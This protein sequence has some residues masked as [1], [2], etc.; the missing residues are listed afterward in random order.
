MKSQSP[1]RIQCICQLVPMALGVAIGSVAVGAELVITDSWDLVVEDGMYVCPESVETLRIADRIE[2]DLDSLEISC[3]Q[4]VLL[5]DAGSR[6]ANTGRVGLI[7]NELIAESGLGNP[8]IVSSVKPTESADGDVGE[9]G[10]LGL[11]GTPGVGGSDGR[12][13]RCR[14][15]LTRDNSRGAHAG[16][17]GSDG[18]NGGPGGGGL[19]GQDGSVGAPGGEIDVT[20]LSRVV[21]EFRI[22]ARG[23]DGGWGGNGG[24]GGF[25]GKGGNGGNGGRGGNA[26]TLPCNYPAKDGGSGGRAGD[27]GHG[28]HGGEGGSGGDGGRGGRIALLVP[29]PGP[30]DHF[31]IRN[32]GGFGGLGGAGGYGGSGGGPGQPGVGGRGGSGSATRSGGSGGDDADPSNSGE[33][34]LRAAHGDVGAHGELGRLSLNG[35]TVVRPGGTEPNVVTVPRHDASIQLIDRSKTSGLQLGSGVDLF[36]GY[37]PRQVCMNFDQAAVVRDMKAGHVEESVQD[38]AVTYG[39]NHLDLRN[40]SLLAVRGSLRYEGGGASGGLMSQRS[41][42]QRDSFRS[43]KSSLQV[44]LSA[45]ATYGQTHLPPKADLPSQLSSLS[46]NSE[47]RKKCGTHYVAAVERESR[48]DYVMEISNLDET[49]AN[50]LATLAKTAASVR[51]KDA[52]TGSGG[53]GDVEIESSFSR[54]KRMAQRE[55]T[56]QTR[57]NRFGLPDG[58]EIPSS[59]IDEL[60]SAGEVLAELESHLDGATGAIVGYIVIPYARFSDHADRFGFLEVVDQQIATVRTLID[61]NQ[62]IAESFPDLWKAYFRQELVDL[63]QLSTRLLEL[64][65]S[66]ANPAASAPDECRE[67]PQLPPV[68]LLRAF[69]DGTLVAHCD[70]SS[71]VSVYWDGE[72]MFPEYVRAGDASGSYL[73]QRGYAP[74]LDLKYQVT[75]RPAAGK[76][77]LQLMREAPIDSS[78][79]GQGMVAEVVQNTY[80]DS[81]D[82]VAFAEFTVSFGLEEGGRIEKSLG[83]PDIVDWTGCD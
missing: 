43:S 78:L 73:S 51:Y 15:S 63:N 80:A 12:N 26:E 25:G 24:N 55:G 37:E 22:E 11:D 7:A 33:S 66:C 79:E 76:V 57:I 14:S 48:L 8:P 59:E 40:T 71:G 34:G 27:G 75:G 50:A 53:S 1:D 65:T 54:F 29:G 64:R 6:L 41:N 39:S 5:F 13:S 10:P 19:K 52:L 32:D 74:L 20:V 38:V 68:G 21:G 31:D 58:I 44:V 23:G 46:D 67:F 4:Q 56:M 36:A 42:K 17:S 69:S 30:L 47:F 3:E 77:R 49:E 82:R 70:R 72:V 61:E 2:F 28:G 83:K 45:R 16:G 9:F 35:R 60:G 81:K 18:S 62:T